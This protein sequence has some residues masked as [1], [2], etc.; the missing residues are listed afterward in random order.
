MTGFFGGIAFFGAII[1]LPDV[2][3]RRKERQ[4]EHRPAA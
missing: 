2:H 4:P 3:A 1:M